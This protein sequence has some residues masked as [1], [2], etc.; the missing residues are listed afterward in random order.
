MRTGVTDITDQFIHA[1]HIGQEEIGDQEGDDK[2]YNEL[3]R[4]LSYLLP[5]PRHGP[6]LLLFGGIPVDPVF[7]LTE[8]HLHEDGLRT[9]PATE[10][11]AEYHG[12]QDHKYDEGQHPDTE[13][14]KILWPEDHAKEDEL[15]FNDI[16]HE[17]WFIIHLDEREYKEDNE[18]NDTEPG[19]QVIQPAFWFFGMY[20]I[21]FTLVTDRSH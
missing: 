17:Q 6:E 1:D 14:E 7:D 9:S 11:P 15:S 18:I 19:T 4:P 12:E 2:E 16:E 8:D 10:H 5:V 20:I 13:D 3:D 21:T